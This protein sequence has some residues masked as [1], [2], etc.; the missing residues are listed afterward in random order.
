[1]A[2]G[3]LARTHPGRHSSASAPSPPIT[4]CR[5]CGSTLGPGWRRSATRIRLCS[6]SASPSGASTTRRPMPE[7]L[8]RSDQIDAV[9]IAT[10]NDTHRPIAVA[11]ARA[12]QARH[13]RE[14]AGPER[15]RG[16]RDVRGGAR[17][18]GRAHDGLHVSFRSLDALPPAPAQVGRAGRRP[19]ISARSGSSTGPRRAGAGGSTRIRPVPATSST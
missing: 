14:A 6:R 7:A 11:A 12:G 10:P 16:P 5:A 4:T 13:V 8:C 19:G 18:G 3:C 2:N 1:M 17:R 15:R 9:I